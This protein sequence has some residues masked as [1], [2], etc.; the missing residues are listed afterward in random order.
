MGSFNLQIFQKTFGMFP[1][2]FSRAPG[3]VEFIGNHT[4][5]NGG[6]VIGS[7]I[8]RE[9]A[10]AVASRD[11]TEIHLASSC[12]KGKVVLSMDNIT[13]VT[14]SSAWVNYPLGVLNAL[15]E[16]GIPIE[17]GFSMWIDGNLPI[18]MGMSSSA[19]LELSTAMGIL[20][21]HSIDIDLMQIV[22]LCRKAE[23]EFVGVPCG[24][25]DQSVSAFGGP[26]HLVHID[27]SLNLISELPFPVGCQLWIFD[28][29]KKH[30][31][32]DSKYS[33]R[34]RE[35]H[36]AFR[37][38]KNEDMQSTCLAQISPEVVRSSKKKLGDILYRRA[39]HVTEEN[40]RVGAT[41]EALNKQDFD[42]VGKLLYAS[43]NSSRI[44]FENSTPELDALVEFLS[45]MPC[46]FGARLTGGGFGGAVM[47]L[48]NTECDLEINNETLRQNYHR[49]F[50]YYPRIIQSKPG[51]GASVLIP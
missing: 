31:L 6:C 17:N 2:V 46:F 21:L 36:E 7:T 18:G 27:C 4:D 23:N 44:Y 39:L 33:E 43:H 11:D 47:A 35:C 40:Y 45:S 8:D 26:N 37:I 14:G 51:L 5:Y 38:L 20:A 19:A 9:I 15:L 49:K 25:L 41:I 13:P 16:E 3:R 48:A 1:E 42:T 34:N 12:M 32:I 24:M 50:G 28:S 29:G 30:S 22:A 10:I